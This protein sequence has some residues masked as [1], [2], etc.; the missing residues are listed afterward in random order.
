[1]YEPFSSGSS[2]GSGIVGMGNRQRTG[3]HRERSESVYHVYFELHFDI[4]STPTV[5]LRKSPQLTDGGRCVDTFEQC[6]TLFRFEP[7]QKYESCI[8][9][10]HDL[11]K[12]CNIQDAYECTVLMSTQN[13]LMCRQ[14]KR[15]KESDPPQK[16]V[17]WSQPEKEKCQSNVRQNGDVDADKARLGQKVTIDFFK[18]DVDIV[19]RVQLPKTQTYP[20]S[21]A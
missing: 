20:L 21:P 5:L 1:M 10:V 18:M 6:C 15:N 16:I 17:F 13:S 11:N 9:C 8:R 2:G 12:R 19:P 7:S 4:Q 3:W 14:K